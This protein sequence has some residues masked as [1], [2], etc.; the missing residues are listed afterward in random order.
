MTYNLLGASGSDTD[1]R[2]Y[3]AHIFNCCIM[4]PEAD[5]FAARVKF[6]EHRAY[7]ANY[8]L[9]VSFWGERVLKAFWETQDFRI[10]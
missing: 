6:S 3:S 10:L 2:K 8:Q 1:M 7:F 9:H 5:L 4:A